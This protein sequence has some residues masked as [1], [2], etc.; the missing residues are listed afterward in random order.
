VSNDFADLESPSVQAQVDPA[1]A[2]LGD[3]ITFSIRVTHPQ[4]LQ[5]EPPDLS[6]SLG[7]FE[8]Y[9]STRLPVVAGAD[10]AMDQFE[11][12]LQDFTTGQQVLP[13]VE[14]PYRDPMGNRHTVKT[15]TFTVLIEEVPPG[16]KDKGDIRGIKGV[17]GPTAWSPWWWLLAGVLLSVICY[18]LWR[19]RKLALAG[20]PPPPPV[21]ADVTALQKL[22]QLAQ[23]DWLQTGKIKEFYIAISE[24]VRAYLEDGFKTPAL[25]RTTS[26]L[27]RDLRRRSDIPVE[28]QV[29]LKE[30]LEAC[31]L[32]K[33]AKF[34]PDTAEASQA[35]A[36]AVKFVEQTRP[37]KDEHDLR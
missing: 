17:V 10:K 23:T 8:V 36:S 35:H 16:P 9:S 33:F 21:P 6:K 18:L 20:P 28:R 31:D 37:K 4:A 5:V 12:V 13:A 30:L 1:T 15:S 19:K 3:L 29:A 24:I 14:I 25:E 27:M 26:E 34:R 22:Q 7:T 32:V 11:A 2:K